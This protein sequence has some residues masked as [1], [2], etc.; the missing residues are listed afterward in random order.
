MISKTGRNK[1]NKKAKQKSAN[2][3]CEVD[4]QALNDNY[5]N[6]IKRYFA[7][8]RVSSVF[9]SDNSRYE[10]PHKIISLRNKYTVRIDGNDCL[11]D[12]I[13]YDMDDDNQDEI[14]VGYFST[15]GEI[16]DYKIFRIGK[17]TEYLY[18]LESAVKLLNEFSVYYF[19]KTTYL[20]NYWVDVFKFILLY[21]LLYNNINLIF[22]NLKNFAYRMLVIFRH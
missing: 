7:D 11:I 6:E 3:K 15:D 5:L 2:K 10:A 12:T 1:S 17:P 21:S 20:Y 19:P 9:S 22:L 14:L 4:E 8:Y 16:C 18:L 13:A